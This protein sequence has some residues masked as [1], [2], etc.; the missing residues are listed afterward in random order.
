[1][2]INFSLNPNTPSS[3][4]PSKIRTI[5]AG[6]LFQLSDPLLLFRVLG[7]GFL[8]WGIRVKG[9]GFEG[10]G[11]NGFGFRAYGA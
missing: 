6:V 3:T 5:S 11:F 1:M 10:L 2:T 4:G 8:G 7:L 9:L